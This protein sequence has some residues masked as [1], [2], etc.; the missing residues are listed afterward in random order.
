MDSSNKPYQRHERVS[1]LIRNEL[2]KLILREL[3]FNGAIMTIIDVEV[4][5]KIDYARVHISV[6][7]SSK[8]EEV[9]RIL[10]SAQRRLQHDLLFKLNIKP[11]PELSFVIDH[12][13][14]KAAEIE[15]IMIDSGIEKETQF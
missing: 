10:T 13:T 5:K 6:I 8:S 1:E 9:L 12:G 11:M 4:T 14:E 15:K 3:E 2:G 7:P